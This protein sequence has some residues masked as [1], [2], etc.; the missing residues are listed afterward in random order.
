MYKFCTMRIDGISD[1]EELWNMGGTLSP[2]GV[3]VVVY[4]II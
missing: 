3:D 1:G 4:C 2:R